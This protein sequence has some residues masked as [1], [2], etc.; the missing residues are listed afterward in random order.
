M[1]PV[2]RCNRTHLFDHCRLVARPLRPAGQQVGRQAKPRQQ[3]GS[4]SDMFCLTVMAGA[5]RDNSDGVRRRPGSSPVIFSASAS[6]CSGFIADRGNTSRSTSPRPIRTVPSASHSATSTR[7]QLSS[8]PPRVTDT[9]MG[10]ADKSGRER[11][12]RGTVTDMAAALCST[13]AVNIDSK[14]KRVTQSPPL[15]VFQI[16]PARPKSPLERVVLGLA[17]CVEEFVGNREHNRRQTVLTS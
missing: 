13:G 14:G 4:S 8:A 1:N 9:C 2:R 3:T 7:W 10:S 5:D 15:P 11:R 6:A 12:G 17:A 16:G